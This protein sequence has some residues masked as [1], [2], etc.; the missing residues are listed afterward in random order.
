LKVR[1]LFAQVVRFACVPALLIGCGPRPLKPRE[2]DPGVPNF[3]IATFNVE[4]GKGKD[5]ATIMAVGATGADIICLEEVDADWVSSLEARYGGAYPYTIFH[6]VEGA[7][8][9]G[10]MSRWPVYDQGQLPQPNNWH[11]GWHVLVSTP[12]G[13]METIIVHLRSLYDGTGG[14]V[15]DYSNWGKDHVSEV[16]DFLNVSLTTQPPPVTLPS[17]VIGDF[18]EGPDG[19]AVH[20]LESLGYQDILPLY[21]PGQFT[22]RTPSLGAQFTQALDHVM[23]DESWVLPLNAYV[24]RQGNSDHIPVVARFEAARAWPEFTPNPAAY[25]SANPPP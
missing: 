3:R 24:V 16:Q 12:A 11:P 5:L 18:N 1:D 8:G 13:Y 21:H 22:W 9:L 7:A 10:I 19:D 17:M 2:P 25:V 15:A 23:F 14:V 4:H 6:P 20:Y